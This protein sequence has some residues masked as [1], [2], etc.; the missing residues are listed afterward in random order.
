MSEDKQWELFP[1]GMLP[2][3][4][5]KPKPPI[6]S[7][8][9]LQTA[10]GVFEEHMKMQGFSINT[11]KA[12]ASDVRLLGKYLG[13]GSAV[14]QIGTKNLNDFLDWLL[15]KRGVPCSPKSYARRVTTLKVFFAWLHESGVLQDDPAKA[16][17]QRTVASPLPTVPSEDDLAKAQLV[18]EALRTGDGSKKPDA[19]PHLLLMLLL[20][21]AVKK[22]EAMNIVPNHIDTS[23]P[24]APILFV[25]YP[26]PNLRYK[27]RKLQLDPDWITVLD[28]YLAQYDV[29]DTLFTCTPRNLEYVLTDVAEA[30]GLD[31]GAL[32][33]ENLRWASALRDFRANVEAD[34]IRQKLGLSKITWRETKA[35]LQ[36]L[37][38]Q[39]AQGTAAEA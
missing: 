21:T 20:E 30:A 27:E 18:T 24:D 33:F 3:E 4:I 2:D 9:S 17:I 13:I 38:E 1:E 12:F 37:V 39:E 28:E 19:R 32:S 14:N 22:G 7:D 6:A 16:V 25:R 23:N 15:N 35:K 10:L 31:S 8:A 11:V 26:N 29:T 34:D 5:N 36:K